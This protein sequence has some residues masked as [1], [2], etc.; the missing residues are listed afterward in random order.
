VRYDGDGE[1]GLVLAA[2][3]LGRRGRTEELVMGSWL[4]AQAES[5]RCAG[6]PCAV[7]KNGVVRSSRVHRLSGCWDGGHGPLFTLQLDD[8]D[9]GS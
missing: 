4:R 2:R 8:A 6:V 3:G 7:N 9:V 1:P 5:I